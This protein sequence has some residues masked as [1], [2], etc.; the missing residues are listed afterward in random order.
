MMSRSRAGLIRQLRVEQRHDRGCADAADT[1]ACSRP[2]SISRPCRCRWW[3]LPRPVL[4]NEGC[5]NDAA[6]A[7]AMM[8]PVSVG[9]P[10]RRKRHDHTHRPCRGKPCAAVSS[11]PPCSSTNEIASKPAQRTSHH[12]L[13]VPCTAFCRADQPQSRRAH[14][15]SVP[16][17]DGQ[18]SSGLTAS[19]SRAPERPHRLG[20]GQKS[21]DFS[22]KRSK[23]PSR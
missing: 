7:S 4:D 1:D 6:I 14:C 18:G 17:A 10:A 16:K 8:R 15:F 22:I 5:F 2:A 3:P 11:I 12:R 20:A 23:R 19:A 21:C 13:P 9:R